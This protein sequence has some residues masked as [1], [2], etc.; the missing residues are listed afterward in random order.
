M[1]I[2][3]I[4][5]K[6]N[7]GGVASWMVKTAEGLQKKGHN[8]TILSSKNSKFN[9]EAPSNLNIIPFTFGFDYNPKAIIYIIYLIK[10]YKID[11]IVTNIE[12]EIAV[13]GLAAKITN[14]PNI[15]RVGRHDDF[16]DNKKKIRFRHEHFVDYAIIPC[17]NLFYEAKEHSPWLKEEQFTVIYNGR[18]I[19]DFTEEEILNERNKW[20]IDSDKIVIGVTSQLTKVKRIDI[21]IKAY[22]K[23][24]ENFENIHLVICGFGKEE[25]NLKSLA[26]DLNISNKICFA[27]FTNNPMLSAAAYDIAVST[28]S[29]EGF[30]NSIVEY[31]A[32][33]T[34]VISTDVGGVRE[35]IIDSENGFILPKE[36]IEKN[37][38]EQLSLLITDTELRNKLGKNAKE[39]IKNNFSE[40]KMIN[41]LETYFLNIINKKS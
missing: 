15:R 22:Q 14:V 10:K 23:L 3:Y 37:L 20:K 1:N 35:I 11:L 17:K 33:G 38:I 34:P 26:K 32:S 30:P 7:W 18:N 27:G 25:D 24:L 13:G 31:M 41:E 40:D 4:S 5:S 2:L 6:K 28:S 12:K 29:N 21:L 19:K 8:V 9:E 16:N 36:N 39:H